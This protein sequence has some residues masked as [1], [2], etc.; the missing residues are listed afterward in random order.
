MIAPRG[1]GVASGGADLLLWVMAGNYT[2]WA[3]EAAQHPSAGP[4]FTAVR[5]FVNDVALTS[6]EAGNAEHPVGSALVKELYG[7]APEIGGW[8]VMIKTQPGPGA[9]T[10][11][12]YEW[13]QG[14]TYA[15]A[16]GIGGCAN[17][18]SMGQDYVRTELPL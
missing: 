11:Y 5:T 3:A 1:S 7:N 2:E 9:D 10:W 12:W 16:N 8:A 13:F 4:H 15:D 14:T 6:L 18:H 17:C